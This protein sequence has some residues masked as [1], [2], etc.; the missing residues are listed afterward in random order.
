VAEIESGQITVEYGTDGRFT[1][2]WGA[3]CGGRFQPGPAPDPHYRGQLRKRLEHPLDFPPLSRAIIPDDT[4]VLALDS[5]TPQSPGLIAEVWRVLHAAGVDPAHVTVLQPE[6]QRQVPLEDPRGELPPDVRNGVKWKVHDARDSGAR[7]YLASTSRGERIYL[8]RELI[9]A[10]V[11]ISV[12]YLAYD[13]LLGYRG[14][15]SV[16]YPGLSTSDA[17]SRSHGQGHHELAPDAQRPIRQI[18]DEVA[19]LLGVQFSVQVVPSRGDGV[20]AVLA[21]CSE[22]VFAAG[23]RALDHHWRVSAPERADLVLLAV[24]ADS[25]G[26]GWPQVGAALATGRNLVKRGGKIIVLS[27]LE[28]ELGPGMEMVRRAHEPRDVLKPLRLEAPPDLLPATQFAD[29]VDWA[30]VYLLSRLTGDVVDD[31]FCVPIESDAEILR[32]LAWGESRILLGGGQHVY[33]EVRG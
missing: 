21:G 18:V 22:S 6:P 32:L 9:E 3:P 12:G 15:S 13:A 16:L 23:K 25:R 17:M 1:C 30:D 5:Y 7:A 14:T 2:E 26:H 4:V 28:Q 31:L 33:G 27:Q 10:D 24:E 19:W 20:A 8:A 11:V 29:A